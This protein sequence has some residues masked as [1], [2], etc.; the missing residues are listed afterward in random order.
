MNSKVG[1]LIVLIFIGMFAIK[2]GPVYMAGFTVTSMAE[3]LAEEAAAKGYGTRGIKERLVKRFDSNNIT[4]LKVSDVK[5][6][7]SDSE[8]MIN[9]NYEERV[10]FVF[11]IDVV[12]RFEDNTFTFPIK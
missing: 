4:A 6:D 5:V 2:V 7:V 8:V 1:L 9:A 12:V 3:S 11:N 10:P